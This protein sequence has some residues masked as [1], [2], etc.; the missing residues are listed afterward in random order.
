[1]TSSDSPRV[2]PRTGKP[3]GPSKK[4][5]VLR[6]LFPITGLVALIWFLFRVLPKPSR[7]EYPCQRIAAP[8]ASSFVVWLVGVLGSGMIFHRSKRLLR[9]SRIAFTCAAIL[10]GIF[11]SGWTVSVLLQNRSQAASV[12]YDRSFQWPANQ[13]VGVGK[14]IFPGRVAWVRNPAAC[15]WAGWQNGGG[16]W[17]GYVPGGSPINRVDQVVVDQMMATAVEWVA[18]KDTPSAAWDALFKYHNGG[19]GYQAGQKIVIKLNWVTVNAGTSRTYDNVDANGNQV[20]CNEYVA[21]SRELCLAL[22]KQLVEVVG[23]AQSDIYIG[24]PTGYYPNLE[25]NYLHATYPNVHYMSRWPLPGRDQWTLFSSSSDEMFWSYSNGQG[26]Y[27]YQPGVTSQYHDYL[28]TQYHDATYYINFAVLKS[29]NPGVTLCGK[30]HYGD[31]RQP[32]EPGHYDVHTSLS[33]T[34][35]TLGHYRE[36]V[37]LMGHQ[38]IGGKTLLCFVDGLWSGYKQRN[39]NPPEKFRS[40]PFNGDWPASLLA[41]QDQVAIDSVGFDILWNEG[42]ASWDYPPEAG[43]SLWPNSQVCPPHLT[44]TI[45]ATDYLVEAALA[46]NPPSGTVYDPE[47]DGTRLQSLGTHEHWNANRL[48]SRNLGNGNGI[49]LVTN[50]SPMIVARNIFYYNS[51]YD[52][53]DAN[54]AVATDKLALRPGGTASPINCSSYSLGING[55]MVDFSTLSGTPTAADFEFRM[56]NG[57]TDPA[58][59]AIAPAPLSV[60]VLPGQ[61]V[62]GTTRVKI[63]WDDNQI[64]QCWLKVKVLATSATGLSTPDVFYFGNAIGD[65]GN[66]ATDAAVTPADQVAVRNN[67]RTAANPATINDPWDFNRDKRVTPTDEIICRNHGASQGSGTCVQM[68]TAPTE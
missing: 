40:A 63:V 23:V 5:I 34:V 58:T 7:A 25:Y 47:R 32:S 35:H 43:Y 60:R 29:H 12:L 17:S 14:G 42:T 22:L 41:S 50:S 9:H 49:E 4:H 44:R 27:G 3:I 37:D 38:G 2:C 18:G 52:T 24:D 54:Q 65:T 39:T 67:P 46:N 31:L 48:Y 59:W 19:T 13:P 56:G 62:G 68:F 45:G 26:G 10:T 51:S 57:N 6:L 16:Y 64:Q 55:I 15:N 30:N 21:N 61:G 28:P 66:S 11:V 8:L 1:M 53:I 20:F 36:L 33:D